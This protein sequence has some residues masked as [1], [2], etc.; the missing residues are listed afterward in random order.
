VSLGKEHILDASIDICTREG[1]NKGGRERKK[2]TVRIRK[3]QTKKK[4]ENN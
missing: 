4:K 2:E 1:V 3:K